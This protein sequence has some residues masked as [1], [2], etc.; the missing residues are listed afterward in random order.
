MWHSQCSA[1]PHIN[2]GQMPTANANSRRDR[3][4]QRESASKGENAH[5]EVRRTS[6]AEEA[7]SQRKGRAAVRQ[8]SRRRSRPSR[9]AE[10]S[11]RRVKTRGVA[12]SFQA[13]QRF[14]DDGLAIGA[15]AWEQGT[16]IR[17]G[18]IALGLLPP[19]ADGADLPVVSTGPLPPCTGRWERRASVPTALGCCS[20]CVLGEGDGWNAACCRLHRQQAY[21]PAMSGI[22]CS[23]RDVNQAS[24]TGSPILSA[25]RSGLRPSPCCRGRGR[26]SG[27]AWCSFRTTYSQRRGA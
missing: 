20:S 7:R 15:P 6:G 22:S 14:R 19:L 25:E 1:L 11:T 27:S 8:R 12:E 2:R 17:H 9:S 18:C 13:R 16:I 4:K 23:P 21:A 26:V 24:T 10:Q 3:N 5:L